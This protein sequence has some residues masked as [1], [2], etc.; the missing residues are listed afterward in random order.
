M[1]DYNK[2]ISIQASQMRITKENRK[3]AKQHPMLLDVANILNQDDYNAFHTSY[4]DHINYNVTIQLNG[5]IPILRDDLNKNLICLETKLTN[6]LV[7]KEQDTLG[8]VYMRYYCWTVSEHP[9]MT[10]YDSFVIL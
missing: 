10:I 7:K 3:K 1:N 5:S 9:T 4:I 6:V 8:S 2:Q